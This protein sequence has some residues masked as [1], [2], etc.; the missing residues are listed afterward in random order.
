MYFDEEAKQWDTDY[1]VQRAKKISKEIEN[2]IISGEGLTALDFGCGTGLISFNLTHKFSEIMLMDL[3]EGMIEEL[4]IKVKESKITNVNTWCG[5]VLTFNEDEKFDV[6]Y[7]SMALHHIIQLP[8][9]LKKLYTM[10]NPSGKIIIIELRKDDGTFHEE[11]QDY[12]GHNGFEIKEME[13]ILESV[14]LKEISSNVFYSSNKMV[15]DKLHPYELF[16]MCGIK[17]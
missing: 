17:K 16:S 2:Y 3:S 15:G 14:G 4:R 1:R 6:I 8:A 11:I 5:D 10:L 7:T 12:D 13:E 9:I